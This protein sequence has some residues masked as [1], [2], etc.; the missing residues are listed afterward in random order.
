MRGTK[1]PYVSIA[2]YQLSRGARLSV[3]VPSRE[4]TA[5]TFLHKSSFVDFITL[6]VQMKTALSMQGSRIV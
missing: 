2:I 3:S 4:Q 1:P 6:T 5:T